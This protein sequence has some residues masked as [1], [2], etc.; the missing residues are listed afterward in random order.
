MAQMAVSDQARDCSVRVADAAITKF[1]GN[2]TN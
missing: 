2:F 1:C